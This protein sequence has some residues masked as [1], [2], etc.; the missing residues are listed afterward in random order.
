MRQAGILA[1]AGLFALDHNYFRLV[2]D[3]TRAFTL[4][5]RLANLEGFDLNLKSVQTNMLYVQ[6]E[7]LASHVVTQLARHGIDVLAISTHLI[8]LVTHLHITDK[9]IEKTIDVF[10]Q[11]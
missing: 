4:A 2:E 9:D 8:R 11:I 3:H 1:A 10:N 6:T 5:Q 7:A